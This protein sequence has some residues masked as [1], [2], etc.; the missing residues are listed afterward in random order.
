MSDYWYYW[1]PAQ[2]DDKGPYV[3]LSNSTNGT[4]GHSRVAEINGTYNA[5]VFT[6]E[7]VRLLDANVGNTPMYIYL[8]YQ[9]VH[10]ACSGSP[11]S[12]AVQTGKPHGLQAPCGT[13]D[14][15]STQQEDVDKVQGAMVTEL[16][17]GVGNVTDAFKAADQWENTVLFLVSDNGAQLDHGYNHPLRGGKHT[18][19]EGGVRVA[20]FIS[21]PLIPEARRGTVWTGMAHSSDWYRTVFEGMAGGTLPTDSNGTATGPRAPDGFNLWCVCASVQRVICVCV[22]VCVCML[23]LSLPPHPSPL[24]GGVLS[25]ASLTFCT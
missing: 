18:F 15:Y 2:C 1:S 14:M 17:Y 7:V 6:A 19:F 5:H 10:L 12:A 9:N 21:S 24:V 16:D 22:C 8:A 13:V 25:P 11:K 23:F 3:D 20:C 4:I